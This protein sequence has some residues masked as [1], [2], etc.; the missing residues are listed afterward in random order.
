[1]DIAGEESVKDYPY[2]KD[3]M[4]LVYN[5]SK[6]CCISNPHKD[7]CICKWCIAYGWCLV[8]RKGFNKEVF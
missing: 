1:M 4:D 5:I 2:S 8:K 3:I 7:L 6:G